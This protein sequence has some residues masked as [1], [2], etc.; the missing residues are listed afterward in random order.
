MVLIDRLILAID[1]FLRDCQRVA[2]AERLREGH[3]L[4]NDATEGPN[5]S[6]LG[7]GLRLDNLWARVKDGADERLHH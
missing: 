2:R 6:F 7:V 5:V 3:Q 1:D 4:V